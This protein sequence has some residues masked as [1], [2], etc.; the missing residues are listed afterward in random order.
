MHLHLP[1]T[2]RCLRLHLQRFAE[3]LRR[4]AEVHRS[5]Q[6]VPESVPHALKWLA[7]PG[8]RDTNRGE[9]P[10]SSHQQSR[11]FGSGTVVA[12]SPDMSPQHP[13]KDDIPT[14]SSTR[15]VVQIGLVVVAAVV[16]VAMVVDLTLDP[17]DDA[18]DNIE[19]MRE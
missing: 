8:R 10:H 14:K 11:D 17:Q 2:P 5:A 12:S 1:A 7:I 19:M 16:A 18:R 4:G 13:T 3:R 9:A 15:L 6:S